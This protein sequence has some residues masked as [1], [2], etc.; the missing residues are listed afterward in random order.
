MLDLLLV[1]KL[2]TQECN[3]KQNSYKT[4]I[5]RDLYTDYSCQNV[6]AA[7]VC[8][9]FDWHVYQG[10]QPDRDSSPGLSLTGQMLYR[11]SYW[12]LTHF[13]LLILTKSEPRH[14]KLL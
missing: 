6:T 3:Y 13:L 4:K 11:L 14:M 1:K 2:N 5:E 9:S 10:V 8:S 7:K 12:L